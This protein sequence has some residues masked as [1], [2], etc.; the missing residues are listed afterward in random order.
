VPPAQKGHVGNDC[1]AWMPSLALSRRRGATAQPSCS[2]SLLTRRMVGSPRSLSSPRC[3][4][5][6]IRRDRSRDRSYREAH[7]WLG[8]FKR[9]KPPARA[10]PW[11]WSHRRHRPAPSTCPR[12]RWSFAEK[13][14][15]LHP[16]LP[17]RSGLRPAAP[18]PPSTP[19]GRAFRGHGRPLASSPDFLP[20][21]G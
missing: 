12:M 16:A 20:D 5:P 14:L 7:P 1:R 2:R 19:V 13:D 4:C 10:D 18:I 21:T 9:R 17:L 8:S 6:P 3:S 15:E 11:R